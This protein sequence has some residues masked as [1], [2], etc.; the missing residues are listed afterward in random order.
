MRIT[1]R[2]PPELILE[3]LNH[4]RDRHLRI[5]TICSAR[6]VSRAWNKLLS[7]VLYQDTEIR[8]TKEKGEHGRR[9]RDLVALCT[10]FSQSPEICV[11]IRT[12]WIKDWTSLASSNYAVK[13]LLDE[14]HG[15]GESQGDD[16][17]R[18]GDKPDWES[19]D[20][21]SIWDDSESSNSNAQLNSASGW[22]TYRCI[23]DPA[24]LRRTL[25]HL[26]YLKELRLW[27]VFLGK[28]WIRSSSSPLHAE[29]KPICLKKLRITLPGWEPGF[30]Q[31]P[32]LLFNAMSVVDSVD[33][34]RLNIGHGHPRYLDLPQDQP[35]GQDTI[36][37]RANC[38]TVMRV[39]NSLL[40]A[41]ATHPAFSS[42]SSLHLDSTRPGGLDDLL[43]SSCIRSNLTYLNILVSEPFPYPGNG[44]LCPT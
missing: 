33:E 31:T 7:P 20:E 23:V 34:L 8:L 9:T 36:P 12:L 16:T 42:L 3:F 38:L 30:K 40:S 27:H 14:Q 25:S 15:E 29:E 11:C 10:L 21:E 5:K 22:S 17:D 1:S 44:E 2:L 6:L 28:P 26:P 4:I 37:Y 18:G 35:D 41:I 43:S 13:R 19:T 39:Q 24:L 32:Q